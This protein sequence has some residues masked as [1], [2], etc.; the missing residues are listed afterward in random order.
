[1]L[2]EAIIVFP[3]L[4]WCLYLYRGVNIGSYDTHFI[5]H[6]T[7]GHNLIKR[8]PSPSVPQVVNSPLVSLTSHYWFIQYRFPSVSHSATIL[9]MPKA[10]L[11][12]LRSFIRSFIFSGLLCTDRKSV[13]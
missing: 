7:K 11:G 2:R 6:V 8:V 3:T 10:I 4:V 9:W 1:M 13:V 5:W 12:T